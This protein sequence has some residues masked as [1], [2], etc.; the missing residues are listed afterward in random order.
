LASD[1]SAL[2]QVS[3]ELIG[4]N[5]T[6]E[7]ATLE[8]LPKGLVQFKPALSYQESLS[9]MISADGL[10]IVDAP[11]EISVF[12]PS[13]LIDYIGAGRPILG[14]TPPGA[15]ARL[16]RELGGWI[17]DPFAASAPETLRDFLNFL[18]LRKKSEVI[19]GHPSVR[20]RYEATEIGK[21]FDAI[22]R[23]ALGLPP[24]SERVRQIQ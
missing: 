18:R 15:A 17:A 1:P 16:I 3:F 23:E 12:L 2:H 24:G 13:K 22:A 6:V 11:A 21:S 14:I 5:T 8:G 10:L 20:A 19:W 7:S 4:D 9:L